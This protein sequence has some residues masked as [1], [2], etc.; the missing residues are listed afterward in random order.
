MTVYLVVYGLIR[1]KVVGSVYLSN[2]INN[3]FWLITIAIVNTSAVMAEKNLE[4]TN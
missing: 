2:Q 3:I 1:D 4:K